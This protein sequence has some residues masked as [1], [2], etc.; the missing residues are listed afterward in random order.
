MHYSITSP[1][2]HPLQGMAIYSNIYSS[3]ARMCISYYAGNAMLDTSGRSMVNITALWSTHAR[4]QI[5]MSNSTRAAL[6]RV[7]SSHSTAACAFLS[8]LRAVFTPCY[9]STTHHSLGTPKCRQR[10][11][12]VHPS[13]TEGGRVR[14]PKSP[15]RAKS[16][17]LLAGQYSSIAPLQC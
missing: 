16:L 4:L 15:R 17:Y 7:Q 6:I 11:P 3:H 14:V 1:S 10:V 12:G 9:S 8:R 2:R 13:T 5:H